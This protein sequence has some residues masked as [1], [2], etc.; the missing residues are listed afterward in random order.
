[1]GKNEGNNKKKR[2]V[3]GE[4][5]IKRKS[6][7]SK[8]RHQDKNDKRKKNA[9]SKIYKIWHIFLQVRQFTE[10]KEKKRKNVY[11]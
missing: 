11:R 9:N 6:G 8:K 3:N 7:D 2:K 4:T 5:W 10:E 1:M